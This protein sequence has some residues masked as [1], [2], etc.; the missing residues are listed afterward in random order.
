MVKKIE[1]LKG[2][3]NYRSA[4]KRVFSEMDAAQCKKVLI[5]G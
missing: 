1:Q 4:I 3:L 5:K 2:V